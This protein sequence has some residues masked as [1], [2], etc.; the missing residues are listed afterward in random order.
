[1]VFTR[2]LSAEERAYIAYLVHDK[3]VSVKHISSK[4]GVS[5]A[6]I[7]RLKQTKIGGRKHCTRTPVKHP[8][9]RPKKLTTQD[10]RHL[11]RQL[12]FS[13]VFRPRNK[14]V[15]ANALATTFKSVTAFMSS[16]A[17]ASTS[18]S[19]LPTFRLCQRGGQRVN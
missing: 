18:H 19:V 13:P 3:N 7:Y 16:S 1:M 2:A 17:G 9:G 6:T 4:T 11:L 15:S 12:L 5:A 8:G 14:L 10:E